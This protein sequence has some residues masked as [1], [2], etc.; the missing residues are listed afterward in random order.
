MSLSTLYHIKDAYWGGTYYPND[1]RIDNSGGVSTGNLAGYVTNVPDVKGQYFDE[2]TLGYERLLTTDLKFGIRGI[3]RWLGQGIEDGVVSQSDQ[4]KYN[5]VQVYGNPGSGVLS[6]LPKM[7][8]KYSA[9]ELTFQ[10]FASTGFNFF[11]SY[12]LSRNW[13]NY[14]GFAETYDATGGANIYPNNT[15]QFGLPI[16]MINSEGLLPNDRTHVFK[17]FGSYVF[18]FGFT[19]GMF[20]QWMSGPPL[21]ELGVEPTYRAST[22]LQPRGTAGRTPSIWDLNFRFVYDISKLIQIGSSARIILDILHF[23]SQRT[24]LDYDQYH[25]YDY[26]Q[27]YV[28]PNYMEPIQ[29]QPP[30]SARLGM[31]VDF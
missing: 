1:P 8:R 12:V 19:A 18:N 13:G 23:A 6:M 15:N 9:I 30:M 27:N 3:Y 20:F 25:Y 26:E 16:R 4:E 22:F 2:F 10:R 11:A 17:I 21:N 5:S 14:D 24:V 28:N 29:F 31:E 7:K